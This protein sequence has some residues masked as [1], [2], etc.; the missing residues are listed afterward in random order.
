M[1]FDII[2]KLLIRYSDCVRYSR[3]NGSVMGQYLSSDFK[4]ECAL[5]KGELL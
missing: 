1:D 3:K 4:K 5:V 2:H